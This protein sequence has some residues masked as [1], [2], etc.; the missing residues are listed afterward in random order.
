MN[1]KKIKKYA[2]IAIYAFLVLLLPRAFMEA[3]AVFDLKHGYNGNVLGTG[4]RVLVLGEAVESGGYQNEEG[5][6]SD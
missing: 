5:K 2:R 6:S 1:Y 3:K 4:I